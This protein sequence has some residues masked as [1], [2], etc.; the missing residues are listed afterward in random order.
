MNTGCPYCK[1]KTEGKLFNYLLKI[2]PDIISQF[3]ID[4]CK[5]KFKLPFDFCIPSIKV[6]IELDG[7]QHFIQVSNWNTPDEAIKIDIFKMKKA[8]DLGYKIIRIFQE[9]V[10][11]ND[12][13]WLEKKLLPKI[14]LKDNPIFISKDN[15]LYS[16]HIELFNNNIDKE[17]INFNEIEL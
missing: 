5:N 13:I 6:I 4:S 3:K 10:Y 14:I 9:D 1:N 15:T 7:R 17:L 2:Y 16:K 12:E 8:I 11:N